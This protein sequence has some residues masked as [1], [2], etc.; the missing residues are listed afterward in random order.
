[1]KQLA[2]SKHFQRQLKKLSRQDQAKAA[3]ALKFLLED[4]QSGT[5][6]PGLGF[7]K[8]N[9]DKYEI[10]ADIRLRIV[11]KADRNTLVCHAVGNH[12]AVRKYLRDYRT[13]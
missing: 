2:V 5:I 4:L 10:R 7:K 11:M 8:I 1:M 9:G 12:E 3:N 6:R 13:E